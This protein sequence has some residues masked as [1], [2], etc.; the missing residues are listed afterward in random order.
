MLKIGEFSKLSHLTVKALRFY[1]KEKLLVPISIDEWTGYR[2]YETGQLETAAKIKAYR[3]L[4]LSIDEIKAIDSGADVRTIL[5]EKAK[6][7]SAQREE[8]DVRL[9]IIN[10]ILEEKEMKYQI[11][12]KRIPA[13][14]VYYAE[15]VLDNYQEIMQW[16]PSL[17]EECMRLNPDLK[18]TEPAYEFCEYLDGEYKEKEIRIRH[19]EAVMSRGIENDRIKFREI[20]ET[21]VL[22]IYH[23]GAY[24]RIG[25]AYAYIMKYAEEN[26]YQ[27]AGLA[28]ECYIDGIW[29]KDAVEDWLTEIQLPIE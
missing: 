9:S 14:V 6:S 15:T 23:K 4:G 17:G 11:T 10:H 25:E 22:S 2:F 29:N 18:C 16:I 1:E 19:N 12:E 5:S 24:D 20:P 13:A 8:I 21:R 26:G 7:L 28:R 27:V 3:Q